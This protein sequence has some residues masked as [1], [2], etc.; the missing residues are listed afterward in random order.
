MKSEKFEENIAFAE[1]EFFEI[2]DFPLM[3]GDKNTM[4][5]EPNTAIV[6]DR[7]A[8]KFFGDQ[9]PINQIFRVENKWDFRI[10]GILH[11]LPVNTDRRDE[12][13][14]SYSNLKDYNS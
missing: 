4:L 8:R 5:T 12:I 3:Q 2:M 6:T 9:N 14:L 13:Y 7:I 11:D 1:G 10:I